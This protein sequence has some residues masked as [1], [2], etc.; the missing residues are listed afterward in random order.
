MDGNGATTGLPAKRLNVLIAGSGVAGLEAAFALHELAGERV[1]ITLLSNGDEF[2]YRTL[3]VGE[4]FTSSHAEH[5]PLAPLAEAAG[6]RVI[7]DTLVSVDADRRVARTATGDEISY[8]AL[9]VGLGA[10]LRRVLPHATS[11]DDARMDELLHGLVQDI[12]EGYVRRLAIVVPAPVPWP[13][14]AYELAL[15]ASERAWDMQADLDVML[16]TPERAPLGI[17]GSTA[18][19]AVAELLAGRRIEVVTSA[20]CEM[21]HAQTVVVHPSGRSVSADRVI[22]LPQLQGPRVAGL[23]QDGGGFIPIDD[24]A[25][26]RGVDRVWAAGDATDFPVKQG[27]VAAQLA[28]AAAAGIAALTGALTDVHPFVPTLEGVLMTGGTQRYLRYRPASAQTAEEST[29][30]EVPHGARLPKIAARYLGPRLSAADRS[31]AGARV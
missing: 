24:Y 6:A 19:A 29:F 10:N 4:P 15:M 1:A 21:P 20:Y 2:V 17:F 7:A 27:G 3:S 13:F 22:A 14:P 11:V 23:P 28:D 25:R 26:V 18:S 5:Y 8:D 9:V 31:A 30:T 16:L 12:E